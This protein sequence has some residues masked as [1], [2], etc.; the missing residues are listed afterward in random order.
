MSAPS[1]A[2]SAIALSPNLDVARVLLASL[3]Q[4]H[5]VAIMPDGP[6]VGSEFGCDIDAAI[7]WARSQNA[8]GQGVYWTVNHV[9]PG[10]HRKP[11]KAEIVLARFAHADIDP[12]KDGEPWAK[13]QMLTQLQNA[14]CPPSFVIDSGNGLQAFWRLSE[15]TTDWQ[16][17]EKLNAAIACRFGG[18]ACH[19]IDRL[20]R[21]PGFINIPNRR[22]RAA[23]RKEALAGWAQSDSGTVYSIG[24]LSAAFGPQSDEEAVAAWRQEIKGTTDAELIARCKGADHWH[25]SMT[26]LA[27][28]M[29]GRGQSDEQ[30]LASLGSTITVEGYSV[31]E[32]HRELQIA[33]DTARKKWRRPNAP[34]DK[35]EHVQSDSEHRRE[36]P[37]P[38]YREVPPPSPF[39]S[40]ALG[41]VL[42]SAAKAIE[43]VIQ[44]PL[45]CAANSVLAVASL[46]SQGGANVILPIGQGKLAPLSLYLLTVLESGERKS[47]AD[48][49]ALKPVRD[50]ESELHQAEAGERQTHAVKLVAHE[51]NNRHLTTTLKK[52]R[53]ALEA[54]LHDV[55]PAPQPPL[56]SVIAPSGDQTM[57][58]LFRIYQHGRPSLAMMCDDAATFLGGHSLKTEQ[59][60]GTT[61]NLCRAW[62]G[63]KL[64]RI[65][66]GDGV[67]VLY[68]R[69]LAC[70]LMAQ[71]GVAAGFLSDT[72][73]ADQGLLARFLVS[74]PAGRSGTRFRDDG[75]YQSL[76][77]QAA[78]DL[79]AYNAAIFRL[80]RQP[81]KW[82]DESDR[83][84]G[85]DMAS[86]HFTEDARALYVGFANAIEAELSPS[87]SLATV[88]AF[89][90]K[91][92]E[93]AA[94][95]AG[96]LALIADPG[97][98][99]I[100]ADTFANA[101][102]L[103]RYYLAEA[104]R[105]RAVGMVD[106]ALRK[107]E[108]LREWLLARTEDRIGLRHIYRLGPNSIRD[109]F[110]ARTAMKLL[111]DHGWVISIP[112]GE[113]IDGDFA[114]E[115]WRIVR[116]GTD[117]QLSQVSQLSQGVLPKH[118]TA[119]PTGE[120]ATVATVA[121]APSRSTEIFANFLAE[122][123]KDLQEYD[124]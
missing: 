112:D 100:E 61:A 9:R 46:A 108:A 16:P 95:I 90:S 107:A 78:G 60:A 3:D 120:P 83:T 5:L 73:F 25:N 39:P 64:E 84:C 7:E 123:N 2:E 121:T 75:E 53:A 37:R 24:E 85:V 55:G 29:V 42:G 76:F 63:S 93:N 82:K 96:I 103:S 74:A 59:K 34:L 21:V 22:K 92:P 10:C 14:S 105:L 70:H 110:A 19:N 40:E 97:A 65:R 114:R 31:G 124:L 33:I 13:G 8:L 11:G 47:S 88:K 113:M 94:R 45:E 12:P 67:Q 116:T 87:G 51:A 104:L 72:Q 30:I 69:R 102:L 117:P 99:S 80:L 23:G 68:D 36:G 58:G 17:V 27:A 56:L 111:E 4:I 43:A 57:E 35:S 62:D 49:M 48:T 6:T 106:P 118:Q 119:L 20:M 38:L 54:A 18:D 44:C 71:P 32:T 52:D 66:G 122:W 81:V 86:L 26:S 41:P 50:F 115:A 98:Q 15:S 77:R 79:E 89:A 109:A 1:K 101:V 28:R 91:L